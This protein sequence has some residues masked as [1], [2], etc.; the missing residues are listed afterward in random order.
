MIY[1]LY[2]S[3]QGAEAQATH[4]EVVANNLANA[5]TSGFK[6]DLARF[7]EHHPYDVEH[8]LAAALPGGAELSTGGLSLFDVTTDFSPGPLLQTGATYDLALTGPGFFHVTDGRQDLLTRNGRFTVNSN[9][10]LVTQAEGYRVVGA[11]RGPLTIPAESERVAIAADGTVQAIVA[12]QPIELGRLDIVQPAQTAELDKLGE[13]FYRTGGSLSV[14]AETQVRQGFLEGS[15]TNS[16]TEM[17]QMIQSSRAF[18]MNTNMIR[19]QDETLGRLLQT[20]TRR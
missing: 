2:L 3:A 17:L 12:G 1:G 18:E 11:G 6:R 13:S 4:L 9:G 10:E 7:Q 14:A 19:T 15:G 20:M 8:N 5:S 16:V